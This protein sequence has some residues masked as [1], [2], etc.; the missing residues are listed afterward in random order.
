MTG[1]Q[2]CALPIL[3]NTEVTTTVKE[4]ED[5]HKEGAMAI[6]GEKYGDIVR[7]ISMG[8]Y[9]K[10]LCGGTHV[11]RTG[12]IGLFKVT[13]ESSLAAGVRRIVAVTGSKAVEY[14]Q[15]QSM[16][17]DDLQIKLTSSATDLNSR[18][19]QLLQQKKDLEKSLKQKQKSSSNFD[20]KKIVAN[21]IDV[22]SKQIIVHETDASDMDMLKEFGDQLLNV[23]AS[24]IGVLG[25]AAGEKP[26]VVVVVTKDL[27]DAG[28]NAPD[29]AKSIGAVMGGG[30][31]GRPHL[32]TAGG[33]DK[34]KL[35]DALKRAE[36]IIKDA[37]KG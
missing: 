25:S 35:K 29:L 12:D 32:A 2:T 21:A 10:E 27:N 19:D 33:K 37:L 6:F 16:V 24:G 11:D 3:E 18:V 17:I 31:G 13:E 9:S 7:V 1:V 34:A 30:G 8:D 15:L 20:V 5:A 23:L 26:N 36:T 28:I 4:F 22:D 14:V